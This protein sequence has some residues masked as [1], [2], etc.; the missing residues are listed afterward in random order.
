[1]LRTPSN[2]RKEKKISLKVVTTPTDELIGLEGDEIEEYKKSIENFKKT[3]DPNTDHGAIMEASRRLA[4]YHR[5]EKRG[6]INLYPIF[7][8]TNLSSY[9]KFKGYKN[10]KKNECE[11]GCK[12]HILLKKLFKTL[13]QQ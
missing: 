6:L 5:S 12:K 10:C 3:H 4:R 13:A 8:I 11:K 2:Q 7:G 1:M 9:R